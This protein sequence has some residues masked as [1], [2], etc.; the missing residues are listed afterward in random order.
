MIEVKNMDE[1]FKNTA[2]V[3]FPAKYPSDRIAPSIPNL[4]STVL[5]LGDIDEHLGGVT[6]QALIDALRRVDTNYHQYVNTKGWDLFGPDK[7]IPV[8]KLDETPQMLEIHYSVKH[9]LSRRGINSVSEWPYSPHVTVDVD[10]YKMNN[11][12]DGVYLE[13]ARLWYRNEKILIGT[14][15]DA[16][17]SGRP[18]DNYV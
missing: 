10:T 12:P 18:N 8:I 11:L 1:D 17:V 7:N 9:E 13:P 2:C 16:Y 4:H 3:V 6:A 5:F 14:A 15:R